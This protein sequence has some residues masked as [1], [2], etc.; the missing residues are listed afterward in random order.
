ML[1]LDLRGISRSSTLYPYVDDFE[2]TIFAG[3]IVMELSLN[4]MRYRALM[5]PGVA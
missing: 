5:R 2:Y 1:C 4:H 3:L